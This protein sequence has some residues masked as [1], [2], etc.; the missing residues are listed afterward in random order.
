MKGQ[1]FGMEGTCHMKS[2]I[3]TIRFIIVLVAGIVLA[4]A[5]HGCETEEPPMPSNEHSMEKQESKRQNEQTLKME[6][7]GYEHAVN[8]FS[9]VQENELENYA[10]SHEETYT[11]IGRNTCQWC[12]SMIVPLKACFEEEGI[13]AFYVD[14]TASETNQKLSDFRNRYDI[15]TVP[16]VLYIDREGNGSKL[17]IDP[18]SKDIEM[19]IKEAV[20]STR[21]DAV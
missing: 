7:I 16:A 18:T 6:L 9:V 19:E 21:S 11:F 1:N 3:V 14:S 2:S 4:T 5:V 17:P 13:D 20:A 10:E 15:D 8:S 12:R